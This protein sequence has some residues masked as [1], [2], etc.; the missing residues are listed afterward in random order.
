[1]NKKIFHI[2]LKM[3]IAGIITL[4]VAYALKITYYTTAA[5]IAILSIQW[6]KRDFINIAIKR[7][8]SGVLSIIIAS[9]MFYYIGQNFFVYSLFLIIFIILSWIFNA[10][11]G[12][13]PS[14]VLVSQ[15][16]VFKLEGPNNF[17]NFVSQQLILLLIAVGV[18]FIVNMFYPQYRT[19]EFKRNLYLVDG[20]IENE[21]IQLKNKLRNNIDKSITYDAKAELNK[22][23]NEAH[24]I[25]RDLILQNDHRY[26]T[27]LYMRDT[28]LNLLLNISNNID[29]IS[30]NHPYKELIAQ[31]LDKLSQNIGF[32][33]HALYIMD[34]LEELKQFFV[35][36]EL[37]KTRKEFETRAILFQILTELERFLKLKIEFHNKYPNFM[38]DIT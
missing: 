36:T 26:I 11:E 14:I 37:P 5:A 12:I 34:D 24:M 15:I 16:F 2:S 3:I 28:Q 38:E 17:F 7:L 9:L 18:A 35:N 23:M 10:P 4:L 33:N 30:Q 22:I 20:I 19:K 25:D 8:I 21:I 27:Y 29:N 32:D 1:M 6:T 13:V 31:F